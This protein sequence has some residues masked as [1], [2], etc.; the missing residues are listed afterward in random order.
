MCATIVFSVMALGSALCLL[1]AWAGDEL[2][3]KF[4]DLE[5]AVES[6]AVDPS[7]SWFVTGGSDG[8]VQ[9]WNLKADDPFRPATGPT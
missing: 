8:T 5:G 4:L 1:P 6:V 9:L 3:G 2:P 7:G